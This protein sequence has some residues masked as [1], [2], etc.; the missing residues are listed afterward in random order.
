MK[1][2]LL[3]ALISLGILI[4]LTTIS[5]NAKCG[6]DGKK[7]EMPAKCKAGKCSSGKCDTGKVKEKA[8]EAV[9]EDANKTKKEPA[10]GKCGTGKCGGK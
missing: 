2:F 4:G 5:A 7:M 9:K 6:D 10:K 3:T 8:E 1:N